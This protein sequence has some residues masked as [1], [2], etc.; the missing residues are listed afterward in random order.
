[1][2]PDAERAAYLDSVLVGGREQVAI[3]VVD[4][5]PAWP[6]RFAAVRDR[7]RAALGGRALDVQHIGSTAVPGLAAK[8]IVDVLLTVAD[9]ADESSYAGPLEAA[10]FPL[11][12]REEGHR[13]FRT[14]QRDV[15]VHVYEPDAPAVD[16]YLDL[17]DRLRESAADRELYAA[18]KRELARREWA[19]MNDYAD[20]KSAVIAEILAR[21]RADRGQGGASNR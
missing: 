21:A 20:A 7:I 10:G 11:R 14:P 13:M 15:H 5:D 6:D 2:D 16:A 18:T 1:V 12:V 3:V 8:P 19:D 4:P 17:R 9:V